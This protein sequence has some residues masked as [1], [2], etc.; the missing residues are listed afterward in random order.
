MSKLL[1]HFVWI[2]W[3]ASVAASQIHAEETNR[4][5]P[6]APTREAA[7]TATVATVATVAPVVTPTAGAT[8]SAQST[9]PPVPAPAATPPN[10]IRFQFDGIPYSDVLERFAQMANKPLIAATNV[11]GTLTYNDPNAY[12]YEEALDSLNLILS[13]KGLAIVESEHTL[14]LVPFKELPSLP[15]RILRGTDSTGDVRPGEVITV[16]LEVNNLD[17]KE[18]ADS[19]TPMLSSAG[20]AAPL[21]RGRG[22]IITDRL[23][24]IQRIRSLLRT[25]DIAAVAERQMKTYTLMHASGG[26]VA[27]LLNRTFGVATAPK[28]TQYNPTSKVL[29]VLPPDPNEYITAVY[30]DASRTLVLFGPSERLSLAED[31]INRFEQKEGSASDVRIYYPQS[32]KAEELAAIIRQAVPG[33]AAEKEPAGSAATKARVIIDSTQNRLIVAAPT[34][35]QLEEIELLVNRVDKPVHGSGSTATGLIPIRSQT[36][37]LTRIF[38]PRTTDATNVAHI[39]TQALTRRQPNGRVITSASVSHDVGSQSVVVSGSPED[40]QIASDI[41]SQLETGT[42]HPNPLQTRFLDV[43]TPAEARRLQPLVDQLYRNQ[44]S[45]GG[46]GVVAHAKILADTESGRLIVTAS[47][48]HLTRIETLVKQ[49]RADKRLTQERHLRIL[50][51]KNARVDSAV[52]NLQNLLK[53]AMTARQFLGVPNPSILPDAPNNRLLVTAT[54]EQLDV[55]ERLLGVIDVAPAATSVRE[56]KGIELFGRTAAEFAPIIQQLYAEQLRGQPEP[57]GGPASVFPEPRNNRLMVSGTAGEIARIESIVRQLDA[58]DRKAPKEETRVLRLQAATATELVGLIEKSLNARQVQVRV[59]VDA[60]SNSLI[61]TGDTSAV[62]AAAQLVQQLDTQSGLSP[63]EIRILEL[64]TA[65]AATLSPMVSGLFADQ[66]KAQ[67]GAEYISPTKLVPD[68]AGNRII[69]TGIRTEIDQIASLVERLD[70]VPDQAPGA[71]V[72]KLNLADAITL[73]PVVSNALIRFG[74]Q[75]QAIRRVTVSADEKSNSLVVS[76]SRTDLQDAESV[77]EKLDGTAASNER[78]L[79]IFEVKSDADALAALAMRVFAAQNPGRNPASLLN[80]TPD[81]GSHRIIALA[82]AFVIAQLEIVLRSL[83]EAPDQAARE[84]HPVELKNAAASEVLPKL[85]RIYADQSQGKTLKPATIQADAS[86]SRLLVFG[87]KEQAETIRQIAQTLESESRPA[88]ITRVFDVGRLSEA[89]RLL[90]LAQQ[91]YKDQL[92]TDPQ[93][94]PPD[95]QMVSDGRTGRIIVSA[96]TN[97]LASLD[98]IFSR[99][100]ESAPTNTV[101]ET[102]TLEV[103]TASDVQRLLPLVQ[104]LYQEQWKDRGESDPADTQILPDPAGGR[105]LVTGKPSHLASIESI[106]H[107]LGATP[108]RSGARETRI[109]DLSTASAVDLAVTVRT[110]YLEEAKSRF[111][112]ATPDTLI[113]PDT[114]G[115]RL[116]VVGDARELAVVG[117]LIQKLDKVGTQSAS[118]RVFKLKSADPDKVMEILATALVRFDAY[119]R[120]QKRVSVVAD[121]KTRTIIATGDPKEL[122][123]ASVIIEQLD[124]SLGTSSVARETRIFD[125]ATAS[126]VDLA[127]TVRTLY[128]EEAKSR[129]GATPPD[130]LITPDT[131]GNRLI[132]VG[133]ARELAVVGDLIQKLDKVGTQSASAR[134][135]KLKSADP[136]KVME[137]LATALVRFDAY[138]RPQK[139]VSVV[140][141]SKTRTLIATG[142]P[143]ELQSA[144]V[145]IEQL[146]SSLGTSSGRSMRVVQVQNRKAT[147]LAARVRRVFQDQIRNQPELG[148][149]EALI[150]EDAPSNQLILAG[151]EKQLLAIEEIVT[152]LQRGSDDSGRELRVVPVENASAAA[153]A[154]L[155]SQIF[156]KQVASSDPTDRLLLSVGADDHR[157]VIEAP[158]NSWSKILPL[159]QTLDQSDTAGDSIVRAVHVTRGRA[160]DLAEAVSKSMTSRNAPLKT[161]RVTVT[162]VSGANSL[163]INGASDGVQEVLKWIQELESSHGGSDEIEVRIFKLENGTAREVSAVLQQ[164]LQTVNRARARN[165]ERTVPSSVSVDDRSNSLIISGSQVHFKIIEKVLPTLDRLPERSDREVQ[166]VW[167]RKA[168]AYDVVSKL[169]AVFTN[170]GEGERP[171][172]EADSLN[173]SLTII[174]RRTDLAQIQDLINRLDEQSKDSSIQVRLRPLER[175]A[176]EQMAKMLQNLYPQMSRGQLRIVDQ[177]PPMKPDSNPTNNPP[178]HPPGTAAPQE[179]SSPDVVIAIDKNANALVLSGP[180]QELDNI[181]RII[182]DLAANFYGNEAEFRLYPIRDA[183]PVIVARTLMELLKPEPAA[184]P[185]QPGQPQRVVNSQPRI[186]VVAEPRTR[187]VIARGRPTDFAFL[188]S[189]IRQLDAAGV[190]SQLEFRI[191]PLTNAPPEKVLPLVQQMVT[192]LN[193]SRPGEPLTVATDSRSR[194]LLVV[195]RGNVLA[196]VEKMILSMDQ[197]T[198]NAEMQVQWVELKLANATQLATLLQNMVKPS[199]AGELTASAR[200]LQEQIRRLKIR[201]DDGREVLLDLAHP[202]KIAADPASVQGG[203]NRLILTSTPDN[204]TA[205]KAVIAV[206]DSAPLAEGVFIKFVKLQHADAS[207]VAQTLGTIFAQGRA[208]GASPNTPNARPEG[209]TGKGLAGPL[210]V[211]PD[212]RANTLVLSG[213]AE[214]LELAARLINDLDRPV[215]PLITELKLFRLK[216]A[217]ATRLLPV[218]QAVFAE[219]PPV[220]GAEGLNAQV[221]RLRTQ[222]T[223]KTPKTTEAAKNRAALVLQADDL[224]NILIVSARTD[225]LPLIEDVIEQLDIPSAS[226]LESVRVYPLNHSDPATLQKILSDLY[227][228]QKGNTLR[229]ED[230]P[231]ITIDSRTGALVVAGNGKSFAMIEGLLQQ[232]DQKLPFNLRDI[233]IIPLENA[234]A[235]VVGPTLQ[236]L[237]DARLTQRASLNQGQADMLKVIILT[238]P[239]SNSLLV[240]GSKDGFETVESLARQLDHA[241]PALSGRIRLVPLQFAD[242]RIIAGTLTTLFEQRYA[243]ARNSDIQRNRPVILADPRSNSLLITANQEDNGAIDDLLRKLDT[244][245]DNAGLLLTVVPLKHNDA[246]RVAAQVESLFVARLKAQTLPGQSP[247]PSEQIKIEPDSLNNS[248]I[249]SSS[250][251][252]LELI[253]GLLE[254]IDVEPQIAGGLLQLFTLEFA[255]A[256]R[257]ATLLRSLVNQG[258]YRPGQFSGAAKGTAPRDALAVSVDSRSNTLIISASPE[259]LVLLKEIIKRL[260]HRDLAGSGDVRLYPLKNAKAGTLATTLEQFFRA[261]RTADSVAV[262]SNERTLPVSVIADERMNTLL[263]TGGK[264]AFDIADRII[265]QLDG[266]EVI[267]RLNFRVFPLKKATAAKLQSTLQPIFANRPPKVKGEPVEPITLVADRWVNALLV[268]ASVDDM[269]TVASL[270]EQLDSEPG[271]TGVAIHVFPLAKADARRVAQTVQSLFRDSTLNQTSSV[272]VSADERI[273]AIVVSCGETDAKRIEDLVRKLDTEQVSRVSE[274]RVFPLTYARAESLSTILNTALNTK[275]PA[276]TEQSPNAQSVLQF[277]SHLPGGRELV[278]AALKEAVL[279]TPEARMNSLIVSGPVD[280]MGLIEQIISRLDASSPQKAKIKVFTL[281]NADARQMAELLTQLFKMSSTTSPGSLRSVQ[282]TLVRP[283]LDAA[284]LAVEESMASAT[285]GTAEQNALT[286]T[287]D[288]RT[289][290]LLVGG[291]DHYVELVSQIIESLDASPA[292]ERKSEVI[293]LKNSQATEVATA[294]RTFLDQER[295]RIT[296]VLGTA[297]IGTTQRLLEHEIAVVA[298]Q[299]SNTLLVSANPRYFEHIRTLIDELDRAQPQ[300]QIQVL[301]AEVTLDALTDL[302]IEWTQTGK[303]G[304]VTFQ[305]GT[306]FGVAQQLRTAGGYSTAIAG[307]DFTFLLRALKDEGRLEVL[308]RP[309]IVTSD[310]KLAC[311]NIGQRVP[312]ITDSRVT[313]QGDTVNSFRYEDVGVNLS[314]TPKISPDGFVKMEIGTTNSSISSSTVEIN[315]Y[316]TVPIINQRKANTTVSVQSGQTVIIGGLIATVDDRRVKKMPLLG[317]IPYLGALFRST[318]TIRDRKELL[319]LLTPQILTQTSAAAPLIRTLDDFTR[320]QLDKSQIKDEIKR[321]KLQR[322]ILDPLFPNSDKTPPQP[323]DRDKNRQPLGR[324]GVGI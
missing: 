184:P 43:G 67:R 274:I 118:A 231:V 143:K 266:A 290:S 62:E 183:D 113:T 51:L 199:A 144:S 115:N 239:R 222:R 319:I 275:P 114:G 121:S 71:R 247:S 230:R 305:N 22:L 110:L 245:M 4:S 261:K 302:G 141:D 308:S 202:I 250:K 109:F 39:V 66:I 286:V 257:V 12:S 98:D 29:D 63:R 214:T 68:I 182:S 158:T 61:V 65:D 197:P 298:E 284:G 155:L 14:R 223:P 41:V 205:L 44:V 139:R 294:I 313:Q 8:N 96:R 36:I 296:Q 46:I 192:Q 243:A 209:E 16:V 292:N 99:L 300:V 31:L 215:D 58:T 217:S 248:L 164:L 311:I 17:A 19:V 86:G 227:T 156:A 124:S 211:T 229:N 7:A 10:R 173:N 131:G 116:I 263:V 225:T 271:D 3:V 137:I 206:M 181:D 285:L 179:T 212:P 254:K 242:V 123:S 278:S 280:Y 142:D 235:N 264:E 83:D 306:D 122:Q 101:R 322:K 72:F 47:E 9:E 104:K 198:P 28:R 53:E 281:V 135:F 93:A 77:I 291:T 88:R 267:G 200:E 119:G 91:L 49:L 108:A 277:I 97:Q 130:T 81:P 166:F 189:L 40:I 276:L 149:S 57:S 5:L 293:R 117:D 194:G 262:N 304:D 316:A 303:S 153:V 45:D 178:T 186:T 48:E 255:D 168:R 80:L 174:A 220:P 138:G 111:G 30:D 246:A 265:A 279:I 299:N 102:R 85:S 23:T 133:D 25:I 270:I 218:L 289:N 134:V 216:H 21:S 233:R 232:L 283:A 100:Q 2:A 89:Q 151:T 90:P 84:L 169:E 76:G 315:E 240:G 210:N 70:T 241:G 127:V 259:N 33:I 236:K 203:G 258:L 219:G 150:L 295:Q 297:A 55:V 237:M 175:V 103:G 190:A 287:I 320:E 228:G 60:R 251:E 272:S 18:V 147:E 1:N 59:L 323:A 157:L 152:L 145:I 132:A 307:S 238:D 20:S 154:S 128:L 244:K 160:E 87:T 207:A 52:Q 94:G 95:A 27:D 37:Q 226:G 253:R 195:A 309:Q 318:H 105:F 256:Q 112:A 208:L 176:A 282:Y 310:N 74:P 252:N 268:G 50:A 79:R 312:L 273:N 82:P 188:E 187:T 69:V 32:L 167:L 54:D 26:I 234:D 221:T 107:Q 224:S 106:L 24:N 314:V 213:R 136:D 301:L 15:H 11:A 288:P 78:V 185:A 56:F 260:D 321:D 324:D 162:P 146:D 42:T 148:T 125:L 120:P 129:F 170:R 171:V 161:K 163:L 159:V 201:S 249:V 177:L 180:A 165:A 204:L 34:S 126:A 6:T 64:K 38:R 140:A 191:V 269:P 172:I 92:G 73:G 317:S 75:G 13:M 196:Q 193:L 35:A